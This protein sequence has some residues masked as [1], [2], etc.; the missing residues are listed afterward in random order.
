LRPRPNPQ[1]LSQIHPADHPT[2]VHKKFSWPRDVF[3]VFSAAYVQHSVLTDYLRFRIGEE[4]EA[5][6]PGLAELLGLFWRIDANRQYFD[7][8]V[9]ELAEA[10]LETPQLGVAKRSPVTS[11]KNEKEC[12]VVLE[13]AG[14]GHWFAGGIHQSEWGSRLAPTQGVL[15]RRD[16]STAV[17]NEGDKQA[18]EEEAERTKYRRGNFT[19]V[20]FRMAK[21]P[22]EANGEKYSTH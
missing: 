13:K 6:S 18:S 19:A 10:L 7:S 20:V 21:S 1:V 22:V 12:A 15:G 11:V 14:R 5:I 16:L 4:W 2:V 9:A 3:A 17:E 8:S